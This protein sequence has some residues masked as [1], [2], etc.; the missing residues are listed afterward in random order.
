MRRQSPPEI[1]VVVVTFCSEEYIQGCLDAVR[2]YSPVGTEICVIDN[3][4]NDRTWEILQGELQT[5]RVIAQKNS[6]NLGYSRAANQGLAMTAGEFVVFLNPD[7]KVGSGWLDPLMRALRKPDVGAA[8]PLS[9]AVAGAQYVEHYVPLDAVPTSDVPAY[10]RK[11]FGGH[12][13]EVKLLIGFCIM[14]KRRLLD[15]LGPF[16]EKLVLG[17]DDLEFSWRLRCNGYRLIACLDS[18]VEHA[19]GASF[20]KLDEATK[21]KWNMESNMALKKKLERHYGSI[22]GVTSE[23]LFGCT[24]FEDALKFPEDS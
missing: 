16:D 6:E 2:I 21:H 9:N 18:Y 3:D 11:H 8:G 14:T 17:A 15:K 23:E 19:C 1:S 24:I 22:Q 5:G 12:V 20:S 7:T 13:A 10:L 4:S